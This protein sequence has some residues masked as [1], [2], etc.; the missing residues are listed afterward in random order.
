MKRFFSVVYV[1]MFFFSLFIHSL[2]YS[3]KLKLDRRKTEKNE[4]N[5]RYNTNSFSRRR[6]RRRR[7]RPTGTTSLSVGKRLNKLLPLSDLIYTYTFTCMH[8]RACIRSVRICMYI[9]ASKRGIMI[10]VIGYQTYQLRLYGWVIV[11]KKKKKN[12]N[13]FLWLEAREKNR[14]RE[15]KQWM[16]HLFSSLLFSSLLFLL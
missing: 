3:S 14:E 5:Y 11:E 8:T 12:C 10:I 15:K 2:T 6:R 4:T 7:K 1:L 13:I 16:K 9:D